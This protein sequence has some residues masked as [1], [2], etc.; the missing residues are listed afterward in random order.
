M[1]FFNDLKDTVTSTANDAAD[2]AREVAQSTKLKNAIS[3]EEHKIRDSYTKIGEKFVKEH[4]PED[5]P[6]YADLLNE[7]RKSQAIIAQ[8]QDELNK[9]KN[10]KIC[11]KCGASVDENSSFCPKCGA[12]MV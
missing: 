12:R 2:K 1:S 4:T 7:I 6:E 10:V 3:A 5:A 8:K 9:L 11:P